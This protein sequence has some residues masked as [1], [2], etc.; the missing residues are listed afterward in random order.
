MQKRKTI[1]FLILISSIF[2]FQKAEGQVN[3][4]DSMIRIFGVSA[5]LGSHLPAADMAERFGISYT[6]GPAF[7]YKTNKNWIWD[8]G[9]DYIFGNDVKIKDS[10][11][12]LIST[13]HQF[14]IDQEGVPADVA[15]QERGYH[16][17]VS[18]GKLF[19]IWGPN[20]ISGLIVEF[21]MGYLLHKVNIS[22]LNNSAPQLRGDYKKGYDRLTGGFSL[23]Q[24]IG[25]QHLSSKR[26]YNFFVGLELIEGFTS[27]LR[28][29]D[30][31]RMAPAEGNRFDMMIG[32]KAGWILPI[33]SRAPKDYYYY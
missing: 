17:Y 28:E 18:S 10:L 11:F 31:D 33:Y 5:R 8:A 12:R 13:S 29:Y 4:A 22:V 19:P 21:G 26:I 1:I 30:F 15:V 6:V 14:I 7:T 2:T 3:I 9:F 23:N 16:F 27:S 24:F 20:P 32:L 25:Y